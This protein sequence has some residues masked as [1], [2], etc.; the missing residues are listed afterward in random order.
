MTRRLANLLTLA[1]LLLCVSAAGLRARR[2]PSMR[3]WEWRR[4]PHLVCVGHDR[5]GIVAAHGRDARTAD[6][7]MRWDWDSAVPDYRLLAKTGFAVGDVNVVRHV[8]ILS[9]LTLLGRLFRAPTAARYVKVPWWSLVALGAAMPAARLG[10]G[11]R[12]RV[13]RC[14]GRCVRCGY[15]L[16]ASPQRCPE[17]GAA[18]G[19]RAGWGAS[20]PA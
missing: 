11:L 12:H 15:D 20:D 4:G 14:S 7:P 5:W 6:E 3:T 10:A 17:C 9:R 8:P 13:R 18:A 16:R 2:S 1:S 19:T